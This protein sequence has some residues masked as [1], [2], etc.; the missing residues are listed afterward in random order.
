MIRTAP[1]ELQV[2][3]I[4]L[5]ADDAMDKDGGT[6]SLSMG[7]TPMTTTATTAT[8]TTATTTKVVGVAGF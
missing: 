1:A 5:R 3:K 6:E 8:T 4:D 7:L 2:R